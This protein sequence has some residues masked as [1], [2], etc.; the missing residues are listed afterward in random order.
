[1][2]CG[3]KLSK[4]L[5]QIW[6]QQDH[7]TLQYIKYYGSFSKYIAWHDIIAFPWSLMTKVGRNLSLHSEEYVTNCE[8]TGAQLK[9][10]R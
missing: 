10:K 9:R 8:K 3:H 4:I 6:T 1:M 2:C 5:W 7:W